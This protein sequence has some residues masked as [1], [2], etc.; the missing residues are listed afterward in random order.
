MGN[1]K[2]QEETFRWDFSKTD[3]FEW[4][5]TCEAKVEEWFQG[6][7]EGTDI[8][9]DYDDLVELILSTAETVIPKKMICKQSK[10]WWSPKLTEK[11]KAAKRANRQFQ[12]RT[13]PA[14]QKKYEE[15]LTVFK[16]E[17]R[18]AKATFLENIVK[19]MNPRRPK[20]FWNSVN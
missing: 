14:N 7:K 16:S 8:N 2:E 17:E 19:E 11:A 15:A 6:R 18:N 20:V 5:K 12:R 3:W 13:Y 9:T 4:E 10:G 1:R